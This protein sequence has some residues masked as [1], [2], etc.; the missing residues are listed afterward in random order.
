MINI[1]IIQGRVGKKDT[2]MLSNGSEVTVLSVAT[3]KRFKDA[4]GN[5]KEQ[6]TWHNVSCFAKLCDIASKYVNVGDLVFIRGEIQNKK[7][8]IGEKSG[9]Y[10]YSLHANE[11][12]FIP[13]GNKET[14]QQKAKEQKSEDDYIL[15]DGVPF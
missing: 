8:E 2:K 3:N 5:P 6:T 9:Q 7:I 1:A 12:H 14:H 15:D 13:K 10:I 11:I 4:Q